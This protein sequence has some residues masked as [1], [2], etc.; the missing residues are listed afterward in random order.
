[1][2]DIALMLQGAL[3]AQGKVG[4]KMNL[5]KN[6]LDAVLMVLPAMKNPTVSSLADGDWLA[7]ETIIEESV[8]RE[9]VPSLKRA[10]ACDI[11][12]YKLSKVIE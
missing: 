2:E 12:E 10:G 6:Q 4:L 11:I 9:I 5:P 7:L 3:N 1:M 8:V